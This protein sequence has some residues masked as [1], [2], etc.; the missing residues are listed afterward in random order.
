MCAFSSVRPFNSPPYDILRRYS[1]CGALARRSIMLSLRERYLIQTSPQCHSFLF[2]LCFFSYFIIYW[3]IAFLSYEKCFEKN[4]VISLRQHQV[5]V[6]RK[7][8]LAQDTRFYVE[9]FFSAIHT[10]CYDLMAIDNSHPFALCKSTF[11]I[12]FCLAMSKEENQFLI[13]VSSR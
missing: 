7:L 8:D 12:C 2:V 9:R 4:K 10:K 6:V 11:S 5:K 3:N 1:N 13:S